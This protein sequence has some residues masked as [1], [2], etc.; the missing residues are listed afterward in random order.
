MEVMFT[1]PASYPSIPAQEAEQVPEEA[2]SDLLGLSK[3]VQEG[4]MVVWPC[5]AQLLCWTWC[6]VSYNPQNTTVPLCQAKWLARFRYSTLF[7]VALTLPT[8]IYTQPIP[9]LAVQRVH[10]AV[11]PL[12]PLSLPCPS[13]NAAPLASDQHR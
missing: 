11:V 2:G 7:K 3:H 9:S 1:I 10:A 12:L 8:W 6:F 5:N 4:N 13:P